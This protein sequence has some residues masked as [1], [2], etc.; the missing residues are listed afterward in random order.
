MLVLGRVQGESIEIDGGIVVTVVRI[1]GSGVR[2]GIQA[3]QETKI[4]RGELVRTEASNGQGL[5]GSGDSGNQ[6]AALGV[7]DAQ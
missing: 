2:I 5:G 1:K 3:P 7:I 4:R 6:S